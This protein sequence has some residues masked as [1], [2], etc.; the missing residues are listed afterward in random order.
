MIIQ[1]G[2]N[3]KKIITILII[4]LLPVFGF[5]QWVL[6]RTTNPPTWRLD[7]IFMLN[8]AVVD[9]VDIQNAALGK[10]ATAPTE[11]IIGVYTAWEY[12]INDDSHMDFI[13]PHKYIAGSDVVI[14]ICWG[15]DEAYVT[16]SA[17]VR[18]ACEWKAIEV[19][20]VISGGGTTDNSGDI[21]IPAV[22]W[23][24]IGTLVETIPGASLAAGDQIGLDIHRVALGDRV[25]PTAKPAILSIH[26]EFEVD[27]IGE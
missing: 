17:E 13:L 14:N 19:G 18:W 22:A 2:I 1:I 12:D 9:H 25:N 10:G 6:D 26:I 20:E 15:I 21:N 3:M 11:I 5:S 7:G 23:T 8:T 16:N 27:K 24:F 4:I